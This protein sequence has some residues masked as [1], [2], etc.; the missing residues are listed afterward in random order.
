MNCVSKAGGEFV[1]F[2]A[3][4]GLV[5]DTEVPIGHFVVDLVLPG[6]VAVEFDGDY[7][8]DKP[9][10]KAKDERKDAFLAGAGYRVIHVRQRAY[11]ADRNAVLRHIASVVTQSAAA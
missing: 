11:D 10:T 1:E 3:S 4:H 7:W 8:H 6:R 2:L 5:G 9:R